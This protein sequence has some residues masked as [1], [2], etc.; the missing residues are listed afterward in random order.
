MW[1]FPEI[2]FFLLVPSVCRHLLKCC[3]SLS[4]FVLHVWKTS[5]SGQHFLISH[6]TLQAHYCFI[7][8]YSRNNG[9]INNCLVQ[10][11]RCD[12]APLSALHSAAKKNIR[13]YYFFQISKTELLNKSKFLI[14]LLTNAS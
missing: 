2:C 12:S 6:F 11:T 7:L 3:L 5:I 13:F 4:S 10:G 1:L 9:K 8:F 14:Q